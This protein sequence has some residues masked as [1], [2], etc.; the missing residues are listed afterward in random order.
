MPMTSANLNAAQ[1]LGDSGCLLRLDSGA[2]MQEPRWPRPFLKWAGGKGQLLDELTR[3]IEPALP[4]AEYY[5]P[6]IGG[7]ALVFALARRGGLPEQ[8]GISDANPN[9]I[10]VYT[11]IR[12][13]VGDVCAM[14]DAHRQSN[15]EAHYYAVRAAVPGAP[16]E[17]AARVIYLNKTCFNGLY[18]ENRRGIFN[19]PYGRYKDPG[20]YEV[21]NLEAASRVL[22]GMAI[23]CQP[24]DAVLEQ[25]G[26]RSFVYFDPPYD[27]ISDT[28]SFT[29]YAKDGFGA[30][31][32]RRLADVYAELDRRGTRVMLS[33]SDTPLIRKLY[34]RFHVRVVV[35]RRAVNCRPERRGPVNE[36]IVTNF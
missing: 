25:A 24:F 26:S 7:G 9:L 15:S 20:I 27:P 23:R 22:K 34:S 17:K 6:F 10:E 12:D 32:Q 4:L 14:L 28:A 35:A 2:R 18:R 5:E 29:A 11:A 36:V 8:S 1:Q 33:N 21:E 16:T 31:D 3:S 19:V 30:D 13:H